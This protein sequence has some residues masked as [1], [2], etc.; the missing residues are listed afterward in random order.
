MIALL[1][2]FL[3][4]FASPF[5]PKTR[6]E[7]ENG[8]PQTSADHTAAEGARSCTPHERGSLVLGPAISMVSN[9]S[10]CY[11]DYPSRDPRPL[12]G[13]APLGLGVLIALG[14][15]LAPRRRPRRSGARPALPTLRA[16][17]RRT[18]EGIRLGSLGLAPQDGG[19]L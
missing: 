10:Q 2:F 5:K 4:L 12:A 17:Q 15:I 1:C 19:H 16:F 11:H 8:R 7:A 9:G 3:T 14:G 13:A 6:L 18:R